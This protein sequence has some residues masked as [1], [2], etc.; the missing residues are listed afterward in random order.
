LSGK[1]LDRGLSVGGAGVGVEGRG[2]SPKRRGSTEGGEE[3]YV[4]RE[5]GS[6]SNRRGEDI[7][8]ST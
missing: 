1:N 3:A 7:A 6:K 5:D 8:L 4:D 2:G